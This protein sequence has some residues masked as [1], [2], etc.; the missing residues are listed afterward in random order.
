MGALRFTPT[1]KVGWLELVPNRR[2]SDGFLPRQGIGSPLRA[3]SLGTKPW[4]VGSFEGGAQFNRQIEHPRTN[5][6]SVHP[7]HVT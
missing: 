6:L 1:S 4:P 2:F 3:G 5:E 7:S